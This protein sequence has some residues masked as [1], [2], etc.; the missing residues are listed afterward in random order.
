MFHATWKNARQ[1]VKPLPGPASGIG[2]RGL[3]RYASPIVVTACPC[4]PLRLDAIV[5]DDHAVVHP[6]LIGAVLAKTTIAAVIEPHPDNVALRIADGLLFL[7]S[8]RRAIHRLGYRR[9]VAVDVG[10]RVYGDPPGTSDLN[11]RMNSAPVRYGKINVSCRIVGADA[12]TGIEP[13]IS[14]IIWRTRSQPQGS[15]VIA[16]SEPIIAPSC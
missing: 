5:L 4:P 14:R 3:L 12:K 6:Q 13:C 16:L 8:G 9:Q 10:M 7:G 2:N 11:F 1:R 15:A